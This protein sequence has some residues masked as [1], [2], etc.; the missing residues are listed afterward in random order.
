MTH[1]IHHGTK[2][3]TMAHLKAEPVMTARRAV[4]RSKDGITDEMVESVPLLVGEDNPYGGDP[5][6]ALFCEPPNSAGGRL[7]RLVLGLTRREY[8]DRYDRVNLCS[9]KW[10]IREAR[11]TAAR[12]LEERREVLVLLGAKVSS[13][14]GLAYEPFAVKRD[15]VPEGSSLFSTRT[16]TLVQLPHP[17]GRCRAWNEPGAFERAREVLRA[18]GALREAT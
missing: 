12:L 1:C 3:C 7:C 14:F 8:V 10:D 6:Y 18:S 15:H 11:V 5:R 13:A 9:G 2:H 16:V 4:Q 17:S